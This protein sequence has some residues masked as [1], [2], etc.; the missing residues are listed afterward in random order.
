MHREAGPRQ[1]AAAAVFFPLLLPE[2][3]P[4]CAHTPSERRFQSALAVPAPRPECE[5]SP[6]FQHDTDELRLIEEQKKRLVMSFPSGVETHT[7]FLLSSN[8]N[9]HGCQSVCAIKRFSF[10]KNFIYKE[11]KVY[12]PDSAHTST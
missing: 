6:A 3:R 10:K 4:C 11:N 1:V 12:R 5:M 9:K 2:R 7:R 8:R